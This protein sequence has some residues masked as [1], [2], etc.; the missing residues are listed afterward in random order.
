MARQELFI[1]I[2]LGFLI[3]EI[4]FIRSSFLFGRPIGILTLIISFFLYSL[5]LIFLFTSIPNQRQRLTG[6][7]S[8]FAFILCILSLSFLSFPLAK[9]YDTSW[10]GQG[11]HQ[12]AVIALA[13]GWNPMRESSIHLIR[14]L[15]SQIFAEGYPS[16]LWEI[17]ASIYA[18]TG[19]INSAKVIN[20][21]IAIIAGV[22]VYL[23]LRKLSFGPVFSS[24]VSF[25]LVMQPVYLL[26]VLTFMQDGF[27][28]ELLLIAL[29]SLIIVA[30]APKSFYSVGIFCLAELLLVST[31]YSHL[32]VALFLG[33][34][35]LLLV[36]NRFLNHE[37]RFTLQTKIA[38]VGF[39]VIAFIFASLPYLRN[40]IVHK[41]L[42]YPTN[43]TELMG[44]VR[45]NN[46]PINLGEK[47]K[48]TLLFYG[49]FSKAQSQES[50]DPR[51]EKNIA[52]LKIP[53]TFSFN[54][55]RDSATLYNNRVGAGGPLF[56]GLVTVT[57]IALIIVSFMV[58]TRKER[59]ALYAT[60]FC[61]STIVAL[62]LLAPTPNLL[63][64][65]NQLQILP[66]IIIV[67]I[68]ARFKNV[69]SK[70]FIATLVALI[71]LNTFIYATSVFERNV[72]ETMILNKQLNEMKNSGAV[73]HV[74]AQ[75]FYSSYLLLS[76]HNIPFVAVDTLRCRDIHQIVL[77]STSTQFCI[78]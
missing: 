3:F 30:L 1:L 74:R 7:I 64:Y 59:Y 54:E 43:I 20:L 10:D 6:Y 53:F 42:F 5:A 76:E 65:V 70:V 37:Y 45:Y 35:F 57:L 18:L 31:K 29:S 38:L 50:G 32:P 71:S 22:M 15:P 16:A 2:S 58:Q 39:L 60:Y 36:S 28:Y 56:S 4:I 61:L 47:D 25:L 77:A 51:N 67:F 27:G 17:E 8:F 19:T 68:A 14:K 44:S 23:L 49:I 40:A 55:V 52:E 34:I 66:F 26:Q 48:F 41:A 13:Q 12:T 75:H 46:V 78:K 69:Y 24:I 21:F 72:Q 62:A 11:Y 73:Y 63:R 33:V 9:T